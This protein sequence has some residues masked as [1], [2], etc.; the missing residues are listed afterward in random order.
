MNEHTLTIGS[1]PAALYGAAS[2]RVWLYVHGKRGYKEEA[3]AFAQIVCP[4]GF[5]VLSID[6]PRH[7][8]RRN[9][10]Q[11]FTPWDIVPELEHILAY[12][13]T[14]W[15][16]IS[17]R[18]TSLG[19]WFSMLAFESER[20]DRA[21]FVSP[22][23]DMEQ[24]IKDMMGWA[25]VTEERLA[26]KGEIPTEWDETLSWRYLQFAKAHPILRWNTPTAILYGALDHLS[27]QKT[28]YA[29]AERF[30]CELTVLPDGEHWLHSPEQ[31]A[32]LEKWEQAHI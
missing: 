32:G 24:L 3:A 1:I 21:L 18:C 10:S 29:F 22:I 17:L 15:E 23:L 5:Q 26:S 14:R 20:L 9:S 11:T 30:G 28:V 7:G 6:L 25:G 19:V 4:N 27:S 2:A 13:R 31:L 8:E 16:H 12:A